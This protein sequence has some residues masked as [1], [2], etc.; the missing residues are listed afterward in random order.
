MTRQQKIKSLFASFSSEKEEE[1]FSAEEKRQKKS[2]LSLSRLGALCMPLCLPAC[3]L[4]DQRDFNP[5]AGMPPKP[6]VVAARPAPET[7]ALVTIRFA[8]P[9]P[10]YTEAVTAAVKSALARKPDARFTVLTRAPA[11]ADPAAT[12][13]AAAGAAASGRAVAQTIVAAGALPAQ[14]EQEV[15]TDPGV[16]ITETRVLVR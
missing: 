12:A 4:V 15:T 5:Q 6:H 3:H 14:V 9:N 7:P 16:S 11:G 1:V 13:D 2:M 8:R 10:P